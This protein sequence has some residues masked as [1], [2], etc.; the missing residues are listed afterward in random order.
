MRLLAR[1]LVPTIL[2]LLGL[3]PALPAQSGAARTRA[4][5]RALFDAHKGDFDYLLGDWRFDGSSKQ[6]PAFHGLWSAVRLA[7]DGQVLDEYRVVGD[8]GETYYVTSTIRSYDAPKD[9][10]ELVSIG[11]G[12]GLQDTGT[13]RRVGNEVYIE[14]TFGAGGEHPSLLRIR[15]HDIAADHFSWTADCSGDGG[16]SWTLHCQSLEAHRIGPPRSI[17]PLTRSSAQAAPGDP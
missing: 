17:E 4:Q 2:L 15:Y 10:W 14:Q 8:S 5:L 7:A 11:G 16:K 9:R 6:Y 3:A 1:S 12:N 13:G